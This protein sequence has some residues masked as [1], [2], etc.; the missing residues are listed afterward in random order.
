M[1]AGKGTA[2]APDAWILFED[3]AGFAITPSRAHTWGCR[4]HTPLVRVR[5]G[6]PRR[7]SVAALC[8]CKPG[9][10]SGLIYRP[11]FHLPSKG[12]R[13]GFAW[14]DRCDLLVRAHIQLGGS[15]WSGTTSIP[16]AQP[17]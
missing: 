4:G 16:I 8:C 14:T 12:A 13:K 5:G 3:E 17:A 11:R 2:A 1:A 7:I 10:K 9:E 15:W 6:S